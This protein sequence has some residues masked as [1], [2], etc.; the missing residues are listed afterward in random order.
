MS[1]RPFLQS[2]QSSS[3]DSVRQWLHWKGGKHVAMQEMVKQALMPEK[4]LKC[5]HLESSAEDVLGQEREGLSCFLRTQNWLQVLL[6]LASIS[7]F[8]FSV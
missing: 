7:H 1:P 8:G 4:K 2:W 6:P 3:S 5:I